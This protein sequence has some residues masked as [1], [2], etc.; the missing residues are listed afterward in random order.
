MT[1]SGILINGKILR[2]RD[3]L[4]ESLT[5]VME[6]KWLFP[7]SKGVC[8]LYLCGCV[9][10]VTFWG[11]VHFNASEKPTFFQEPPSHPSPMASMASIA[12]DNPRFFHLAVLKSVPVVKPKLF[13]RGQNGSAKVSGLDCLLGCC[14]VLSTT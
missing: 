2:L 12:S 9:L 14:L 13:S 1:T 8:V 5:L 11:M 3:E 6:V 7:N 10:I 4:P